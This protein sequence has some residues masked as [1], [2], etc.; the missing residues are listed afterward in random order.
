[1]CSEV[2]DRADESCNFDFLRRT[3]RVPKP[4]TH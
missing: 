3:E 4:H 2:I 1:M